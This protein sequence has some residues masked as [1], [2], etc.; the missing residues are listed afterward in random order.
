MRRDEPRGWNRLRETD[1]FPLSVS[2]HSLLTDAWVGSTTGSDCR[3]THRQHVT[4]WCLASQ[5]GNRSRGG[6]AAAVRPTE[7]LRIAH[8]KCRS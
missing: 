4:V 6:G 2:A 5:I 3:L 8:D 1:S 7:S